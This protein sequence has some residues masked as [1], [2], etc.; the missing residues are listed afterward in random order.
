M[1][2]RH[3]RRG[4]PCAACLMLLPALTCFAPLP[5]FDG[6]SMRRRC[7]LG[8]LTSL[9]L[10]SAA[11]AEDRP[12]VQRPFEWSFL[13]KDNPE[14]GA[15][16]RGLRPAELADILRRDLG[17]GKYILTGN[18]TAAIFANDC[19]FVDPNNA[20]TGLAQ[21][22]QALA[23]LFDPS[24]SFLNLED[25]VV[26]DGGIQAKYVAGGTL[27]LPWR[28]RIEPWSGSIQYTLTSDGLIGSQ[29][30]T[31]NITRFDAIRQTF[32]FWS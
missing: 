10:G 12:V 25:V 2:P 31:W 32:T 14:D 28:P 5:G 4:G 22:R 24:E 1:A 21:Y 17:D 20:V 15:K 26:V 13:W 29:V 6:A 30:D 27:K 19:R 23:L 7:G 11:R 18:L 3:L 8:G 9:M 16:R